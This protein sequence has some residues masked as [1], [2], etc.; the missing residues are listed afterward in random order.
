MSCYRLLFLD[1]AFRAA[2]TEAFQCATDKE[3]LKQARDRFLH[4]TDFAD[5][6]LWQ[7]NR[8]IRKTPAEL[9]PRP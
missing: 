9:G 8:I 3:A 2:H 1:Q 7:G 4:Q 5:F 6:E